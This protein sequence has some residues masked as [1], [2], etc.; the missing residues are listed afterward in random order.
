[1]QGIQNHEMTLIYWKKTK[2]VRLETYIQWKYPLKIRYDEIF[3]PKKRGGG[4]F[5][6]QANLYYKNMKGITLGWKMI[7]YGNVNLHKGM[8]SARNIRM[9][10][11]I[12]GKNARLWDTLL[13]TQCPVTLCQSTLNYLSPR[14]ASSHCALKLLL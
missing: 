12:A 9:K 14:V 7:Q 5:L 10:A 13:G 2:T 8:N 1:M 6:S 3:R 11:F 4:V